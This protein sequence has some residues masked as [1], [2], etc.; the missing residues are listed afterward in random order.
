MVHLF[1]VRALVLRLA[2]CLVRLMV[3]HT[4]NT[5]SNMVLR[6]QLRR[7]LLEHQ[8]RPRKLLS[9]LILFNRERPLESPRI[10]LLLHQRRVL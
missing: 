4:E 5:M 1:L 7:L 2:L 3:Q 8:T 9:Q 10:L 6:P